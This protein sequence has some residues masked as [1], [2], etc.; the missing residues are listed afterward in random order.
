MP[1]FLRE[2]KALGFDGVQNFPTVGLIDGTYRDG[3][4]ETGMGYGLE[5]DMIAGVMSWTCSP[6]PMLSIRMSG[7]HGCRRGLCVGAAHGVD[8]QRAHLRPHG[9]NP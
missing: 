8:D 4:E 2:L 3:L 6:V 5:V 1:T 9:V 7:R